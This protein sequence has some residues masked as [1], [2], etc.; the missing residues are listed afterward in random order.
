[1][2]MSEVFEKLVSLKTDTHTARMSDDGSAVARDEATYQKALA[3]QN[4]FTDEQITNESVA[5]WNQMIAKMNEDFLKR[6]EGQ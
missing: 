4:E 1:M 5:R 6:H 2:K 3:G